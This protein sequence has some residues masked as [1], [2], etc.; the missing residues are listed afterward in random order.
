MEKIIGKDKD[1]DITIADDVKFILE[2]R[3]GNDCL[4]NPYQITNVTIYFITREFTD[5]VAKEY[6]KKY[7]EKDLVR[8]YEQVK[9]DLCL[10]H[11]QN[12]VAATNVNIS[13]FG[14]QNIDGIDVKEGERVLVKNQNELSQNGIYIVKEDMWERSSDAN[15]KENIIKG[16]YLFVDNGIENIN[17]GWV[18]ECQGNIELDSTPLVFLKFSYPGNLKNAPNENSQVKLNSLKK[19]IEES[20]KLS[21]FYYKDAVAI[22]TFGGY[23]DEKTGEL[24]P[25]W[26]NPSMVPV[27]MVEKVSNDNI[28]QQYYENEE[29]VDGKF[30]LDWKPL[31]C[32]EGDYFICWSWMPNLAGDLLSN[33]LF[34]SL[35]GNGQLTTSIP[36]HIIGPKKYEILMDRYLP[37]MFKTIISNSDLT[38]KVLQEFNRS[39][40]SGFTFIENQ[41][42]QIIDLLDANAI[43]EQ[44]LPLL[45]NL[46]N[47]KLKSNDPTL[48]RKQIKKA[49]PNFKKK[50]SIEGLKEALS[51]AG[52][53]FISLKKMWQVIPRYTYQ[54]HFEYKGSNVFKLSKKIMPLGSIFKLWHRP[55]NSDWIQITEQSNNF[56][57]YVEI[58][59]ETN[60]LVWKGFELSNGHS[61][62]VI[63]KFRNIPSGEQSLDEYI[64]SLPLMD[65]RDER[66]QL[67]P[68]KNWN[69]HL[70]EEDDD[71]FNRII[72]VRH[73][74]ADPIVWGRIRTE[75]PYSENAYNM[76]EYNGSKRDSYNPCDIDKEFIDPCR[77]CQSSKFSL[78]LEI[79]N[80][81]NE[82]YEEIKKI[83]EEYM[84]FHATVH[85]LNLTGAVNEFIKP[86]V[87]KIEALVTFSEE[88]VLLAGEGQHIFNRDVDR[89]EIQDVKRDVLSNFSVVSNES[90]TKWSGIIKNKKVVLCASGVN[91][92]ADLS[93]R[94]FANTTQGFEFKNINT[95]NVSSDPFEN[96]NLLE[97][98]GTPN[99]NYSLSDFGL[100]SATVFNFT[101]ENNLVGPLFEYRISNKI[102]DFS[103]E[104]IQSNRIIFEDENADFQ[105]LGI[106]TQNDVDAGLSSSEP[107]QIRISDRIHVIE[108]ILPDGSLLL[109]DYSTMASIEG[110]QIIDQGSIIKTSNSNGKISISNYGLV[111]LSNEKEAENIRIGD[112]I[113]IDWN[114]N[115]KEYKIK[116]FKKNEKN[117]FYIENYQQGDAGSENIKI[118][119]RIIENKVGKFEYEGLIL[120]TTNNID[121]LLQ[122]MNTELF[123]KESMKS[124]DLK[125]NYLIIINQKYYSINEIE[126]TNLI[127]NGP[128]DDWS[129]EGE[130][131]EFMIY[132]F[133]KQSLNLKERKLPVVPGYNFDF[134]DRSGK[135]IITM[136]QNNLLG[137]S[138]EVLNASNNNE[139]LD[140]INQNESIDFEIEYKEEE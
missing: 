58:V 32:R 72:P 126:G 99:R 125:E 42:N 20:K 50:G 83:T 64:R 84:P 108:N 40:A 114:S 25:A 103:A 46:F 79:E 95:T 124:N 113:Y 21:S 39:V 104:I 77:D 47:L 41:A 43:H 4:S 13:L 61:I 105:M 30:V 75:F 52:V 133:N 3:D 86:S 92:F 37:E 56:N 73:P 98:L 123:D 14:E 115:L 10:K 120:Q 19:Q 102:G 128:W 90:E 130:E 5:S 29:F 67:Y 66:D 60:E 111:E 116:S 65:E 100:F 6:H 87:E 137:I 78:D 27:D 18:L 48:W 82:S 26:L 88:D 119:R 8:Q 80:L 11:K 53:R 118:Y 1:K 33:H 112:Y 101:D 44:L 106:V 59:E 28:I 51:D 132:K 129:I 34:F 140:L 36:T 45:S 24:F 35:E 69:T 17:T 57:S 23:V 55:P 38:P 62:R 122:I 96:S 9:K 97:V 2:T 70:I 76:D 117:K 81:S 91:T 85:S 68:V 139:K 93:N 136:E 49:V 121:F 16:V 31:N 131:I 74:L 71:L 94:E 127:L 7:D 107:W 135:G 22:K 110:W 15:S 138:L 63:Y 54:E 109:G 89:S 12:V 134:I